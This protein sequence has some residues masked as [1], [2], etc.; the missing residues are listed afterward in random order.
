MDESKEGPVTRMCVHCGGLKPVGG[1]D[2]FLLVYGCRTCDT[3]FCDRCAQLWN[4]GRGSRICHRC[5]DAERTKIEKAEQQ[6]D[7]MLLVLMFILLAVYA[8]LG[9]IFVSNALR[10]CVQV[11][12]TTVVALATVGGAVLFCAH[13]G[14]TICN[15][16]V[17]LW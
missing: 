12:S 16:A 2:G 1:D 17:S 8:F 6:S 14:S 11:V 13:I 10:F 3:F 9:D 5:A 15:H 7:T 4:Y